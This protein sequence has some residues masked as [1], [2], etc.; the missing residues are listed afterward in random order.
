MRITAAVGCYCDIND[1]II[2]SSRIL[3]GARSKHS[4]VSSG[5]NTKSKSVYMVYIRWCCSC[6]CP[7]FSFNADQSPCIRMLV[8]VVF[9]AFHVQFNWQFFHVKQSVTHSH[10]NIPQALWTLLPSVENKQKKRIVLLKV[11]E[12][13]PEY[14]SKSIH[15]FFAICKKFIVCI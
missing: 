2:L 13:V 9:S 6:V 1:T 12:N 10:F 15:V 11:E 4:D 3:H 8:W 14:I 5:M 7:Q